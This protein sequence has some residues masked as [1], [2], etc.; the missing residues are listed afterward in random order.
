RRVHFLHHQLVLAALRERLDPGV[1]EG[2]PPFQVVGTGGEQGGVGVGPLVLDQPSGGGTHNSGCPDEYERTVGLRYP[3]YHRCPR[4]VDLWTTDPIGQWCLNLGG[5]I[6]L[7]EGSHPLT[8][9]SIPYPDS[10]VKTA[11]PWVPT[12]TA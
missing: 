9:V 5:G 12:R 3:E 11:S 2:D 8:G 10:P 6:A 7:F 4:E 1:C